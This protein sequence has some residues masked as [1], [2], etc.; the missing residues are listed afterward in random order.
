MKTV[1]RR[2]LGWIT[3]VS[4]VIVAWL[5][6]LTWIA[7]QPQRTEGDLG[8]DDE[9]NQGAAGIT[10]VLENQGIA[11]R[12][13]QSMTQLRSELSS[14]PEAT[15]L[16]HDAN[17]EMQNSSYERLEE[18][19]ELVP[20][21]QRVF[22]G[23]PGTVAQYLLDGVDTT[24]QAP[25]IDQLEVNESCRLDAAREATDINNI[26]SG[27]L[28]RDG[29]QGCFAFDTDDTGTEQPAYAYAETSEGSIV[30]ADW[31]MLSNA[32]LHD[33]G[34]ATLATWALGQSDIV[35][36][37]QPDFSLDP[38]HH[39]DLSPVQLPD[40]VRMSIVW[41]VFVTGIFLLYIGRRTGP[42]ITEPLPAEVSAAETTVGRGRMY[43]KGKHHGHA[44]GMLQQASLA[45]LAR[46]LQLGPGTAPEAI[47]AETATQLHRPV[48]ELQ[49]L[50]SPPA[51][52]LTSK[53]FV[54]WAQHLQQ[55]E[56]QVRDRF[57]APTKE[58]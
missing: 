15:V 43:A 40:W 38:D 19:A 39:G 17:S 11:V 35:I 20:A 30:F 18:L 33:N 24:V 16:F 34:T 32:G 42:V 4:L 58:S 47:L 23:V 49:Q 48:A 52:E 9:T 22:A 31:Q 54:S 45:R 36:W 21:D 26:R 41:G 27:V 25:V 55:L 10:S 28:L 37:F 53:D 56:H 6:V 8:I 13:V 50:Y 1:P 7:F 51:H 46:M 57:A 5:A 44:L 14:H 29:A 3:V 12:P 2:K